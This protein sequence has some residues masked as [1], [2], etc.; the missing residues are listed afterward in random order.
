MHHDIVD[1]RS[2]V[3]PAEILAQ[4][5]EALASHSPVLFCA[6]GALGELGP[7]CEPF[8]CGARMPCF[9]YCFVPRVLCEFGH[10]YEFWDAS[11]KDHKHLRNE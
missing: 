5:R 10:E 9:L 1:E 11:A 6:G 8:E 4:E 3:E 7:H 2:G